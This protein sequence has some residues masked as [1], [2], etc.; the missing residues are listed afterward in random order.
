MKLW[1]LLPSVKMIINDYIIVFNIATNMKCLCCRLPTK[2]WQRLCGISG[3]GWNDG[4]LSMVC[5][6]DVSLLSVDWRCSRDY[7]ASQ[8][9]SQLSSLWTIS[10]YT[11]SL[12]QFF[13]TRIRSPFSLLSCN[14]ERD[15]FLTV[16]INWFRY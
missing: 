12:G 15:N 14:S 2:A 6:Q 1:I 13:V 10:F 8:E 4:V 3:S 16:I 5:K 11:Y 9:A 7:E